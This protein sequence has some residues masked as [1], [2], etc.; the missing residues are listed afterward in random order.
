M[1]Y[2]ATNCDKNYY[3]SKPDNLLKSL[4]QYKNEEIEIIFF[5]IDFEKKID[6]IIDVSIP[7]EK[8]NESKRFDID[9]RPFY[10]CLE[11]GEFTKF[12]N[13][14]DNDILILLDYDIIQQRPF[15]YEDIE[16]VKDI[17]DNEFLLTRNDFTEDRN[18]NSEA[19]IVCMDRS[20]LS[21]IQPFKMYNCGCQIGKISTWKKIYKEWKLIHNKW[22]EKCKHHA[23]GQ[24]LFNYIAHKN[25]VIRELHPSFHSSWGFDGLEHFSRDS[26]FYL[27]SD[28]NM[29]NGIMVLFNHHLWHNHFV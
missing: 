2:L 26:K 16:L 13:F 20:I 25:H 6:G 24:L 1:I 29:D 15:S 5:Q 27:H 12:Y 9:N 14:D 10:V 19:D 18:S 3:E 22:E 11:S 4:L 17:G 8:I 28:G 21:D 23:T 7:L